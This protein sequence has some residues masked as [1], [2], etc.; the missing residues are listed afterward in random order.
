M[1]KDSQVRCSC[2]EERK[3]VSRNPRMR[4]LL[5][6]FQL[7]GSAGCASFSSLII[8]QVVYWIKSW[9]NR[10]VG[11]PVEQWSCYEQAHQRGRKVR[12]GI[13]RIIKR[14]HSP[15][16]HQ[17]KKEFRIYSTGS[18]QFRVESFYSSSRNSSFRIQLC[19]RTS[20]SYC[21]PKH[22]GQPA[23]ARRHH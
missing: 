15:V 6:L 2:Q 10:P 23:R 4:D 3:V 11:H 7:Q 18:V 21:R 16:S 8:Y 22:L 20:Y 17:N 12:H 13:Q 9:R 14:C 19:A 1:K 5:F